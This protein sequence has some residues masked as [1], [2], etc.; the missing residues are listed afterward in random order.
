[1]IGSGLSGLQSAS[2]LAQNGKKVLVIEQ[3]GK[4]GGCTHVFKAGKNDVKYEFDSGLHYV[5]IKSELHQI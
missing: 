3:H 5:G 2:M 1:V 4:A